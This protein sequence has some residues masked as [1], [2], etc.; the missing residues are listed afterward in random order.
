M[1][2]S[3]KSCRRSV[4]G[5]CIIIVSQLKAPRELQERINAFLDQYV[6]EYLANLSEAEF[7]KNKESLF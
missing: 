5:I 4:Y 2:Y 3:N 7:D 1:A 6:N